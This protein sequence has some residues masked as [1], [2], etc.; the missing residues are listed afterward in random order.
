M[1]KIL[2][3]LLGCGMAAAA[4]AADS[5]W[6]TNVPNAEARAKK[7]NKYVLLKFTGSDWCPP[8]RKLEEDVFSKPEFAQ[9]ARTNLVP[10]ELDFPS[11]KKQPPELQQANAA[12][13]VTYKI[14][15]FPT[16]ILL[17]YDGA[18]LWTH[19]GYLAGGPTNL[20]AQLQTAE[21]P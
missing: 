1:K 9:F 15:G 13:Q 6:L 11:Q 14:E 8:C 2:F 5:L 16:L 20:I 12:L 19:L 10:V 3:S 17:R 4:L 7:E 21:T 18:I